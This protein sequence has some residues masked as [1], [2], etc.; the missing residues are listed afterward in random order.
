MLIPENR[1]LILL[2]RQV[3]SRN[4]RLDVVHGLRIIEDTL[5]ITVLFPVDAAD[6]SVRCVL[7]HASDF[8]GLR[9]GPQIMLTEGLQNDRSVRTDLIDIQTAWHSLCRA[10]ILVDPAGS[11]DDLLIRMAVHIF[12]EPSHENTDNI[13]GAL[14]FLAVDAEQICSRHRRR[15]D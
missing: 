10:E 2:H 13:F 6:R 11:P 15:S 1:F 5:W 12:L 3:I 4:P 8:D 14:S 7:V 9:I